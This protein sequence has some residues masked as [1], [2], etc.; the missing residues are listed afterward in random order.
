MGYRDESRLGDEDYQDPTK[1][2]LFV[3]IGAGTTDLCKIQGYYPGPEDQINLTKAGNDIDIALAQGIKRTYPD[4]NITR[5]SITRLKEE[6]SFVGTPVYQV[7]VTIPVNGKPRQIDITNQ[8]KSACESIMD[9]II[10]AIEEIVARCD[11]DSVEGLLSNI[12]LTGGGSLIKNICLYLEKRLKELGYEAARVRKVEDYKRLV[13]RGAL[14]TA[15]RV[16]DEQ[17]QIPVR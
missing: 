3:D 7:L 15:K 9:D 14:K 5:V 17:W 8:V 10:W 1:N 6:N 4:T 2:S 16:R 11:S 12:I 13:A